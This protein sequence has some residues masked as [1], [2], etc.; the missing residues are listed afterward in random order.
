MKFTLSTFF[1]KNV[2]RKSVVKLW[3]YEHER[4]VY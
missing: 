2:I 1:V 3:G 4:T